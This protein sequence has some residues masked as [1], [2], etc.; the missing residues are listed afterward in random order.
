M[1]SDSSFITLQQ[2]L[3]RISLITLSVAMLLVTLLIIANS[4]L[5]GS[6]ALIESSKSKA[7]LLTDNAAPPLMFQDL[8]SAQ[9]LL[10]SLSNSKEV[11]AAVIYNEDRLK[12][13]QYTVNNRPFPVSL[14]FVREDIIKDFQKIIFIQ[15]IFFKD[16]QVGSLFLEISMIPLYWQLLWQFLSTIGAAGIALF[17]GY[18]LVQRLNKSVLNPLASLSDVMEQ[19]SIKSDY[20]VR[21]KSCNIIELNALAT[22][23][24]RMLDG[25]HQRDTQLADNLNLLE[26]EVIKR[27]HDLEQKTK[28]AYQF[29]EKAQAAS[30]A[31]SEF[32]ATMSHEIRTPMN[33]VLGMTELLL[34]T[35][36]N[37][38]QKRLADIAYRSAESL[39]GVINNI[40]DFSKIESGKFQLVFNDFSLRELLEDTAEIMATQAHHKGLELLLDLPSDLHAIVRGDAERLRQVLVN[41]LGNAIKFTYHGEIRLKVYWLN[42]G[43]SDNQMHLQFEVS[44]T[45]P[46]IAADQ[47]TI[48]FE[49]FTQGDSTTTRRHGGTGLGL[50]ISR[51]IVEMMGGELKLTSSLGQGACFYFDIQL[52]C[53]T[54]SV[55]EKADISALQGANILV[56]DDNAA[57][58]EILS[59]QLKHW[60]VHCYCASNGSQALNHLLDSKLHNK[61]YHMAI[62]DFHM[63]EMDGL[64]LA[65]AIHDDQQFQ[66]LPLVMLS[67]DSVSLDPDQVKQCGISYFLNKPVIQQKLLNCV[68]NLLGSITNSVQ[69]STESASSVVDALQLTGTVL[70][71]EDNLINQEVG[72][73]ILRSIGCQ[74]E[75]VNN[76]LEAVNAAA[77]KKYDLILM[78]CHMPEMDG[79]QAT[80]KI[81][82]LENIRNSQNHVPIIALTA[83]IQKGIVE[84][85]LENG[86]DGYL[87]KPFNKKRLHEQLAK[88]LL[89][90]N[91]APVEIPAK[92]ILSNT[93][94]DSNIL[95]SDVLDGLR[96]IT[97][98]SGEN[99]LTKTITLFLQSAPNDIVALQQALDQQDAAELSRVAHYFKSVCGNLGIKSLTQ[100][101]ASLETIA[102]RGHISGGDALLQAIK[103]D[104]PDVLS[105]LR[106]EIALFPKKTTNPPAIKDQFKMQNRRILL[107]DDDTSFRMITG[108]VLRASSFIVD[109]A[110]NGLQALKKVKDHKP[111]VVILDALMLELN[112]FDTCKLLRENPSLKNIPIISQRAWVTLTP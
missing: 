78:D 92:P 32:L 2:K 110:E 39:L 43:E 99:L 47:Q 112:G 19:I 102:K 58:R 44:D 73:G 21:A 22:G 77:N 108:S 103:S 34:A 20:Q 1:H 81:R 4:Y 61:T 40:L 11:R 51:Q 17:A 109:E 3:Q 83:D 111:D 52:E 45:G 57:N 97:T 104:L 28:E 33:G 91:D 88:W 63:P 48:I 80:R 12:F 46:G 18:Y 41:L 106:Q 98:E 55:S 15:P 6:Y 36:L 30:K 24:N 70:L 79:F 50:S 8:N 23:F 93:E 101:A 7:K 31:K 62:L 10:Q 68:L 95:N 67:S 105:A 87:S 85:C 60:G 74:V 16:Q 53:S 35:N 66:S 56:V 29:A 37:V 13:A 100:H 75:V 14:E 27:T 82:D 107:V 72:V 89:K 38:R 94:P 49:S 96:E 5:L 69:N 25:I 64:I 90:K 65:K 86:M 59:E 42:H 54:R 76:G 9:T 71:A 84:R 26:E